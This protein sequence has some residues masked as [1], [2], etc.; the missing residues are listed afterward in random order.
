MTAEVREISK[1]YKDKTVLDKV[2]FEARS[3]ELVGIIGANGCG[4]STLLSVL[5]GVAERDGGDFLI[6]SVSLFSKGGARLRSTVGYVPQGEPLLEELSA[7]DNLRMWYS[8]KEIKSAAA[9]GGVLSMLGI[10]AFM[11]KR[12]SRMSG[13]MKRR[14]TIACAVAGDPKVL[15]L[16]EPTAS[17][18]A[19]CR[20]SI[21]AYFD[22]LKKRGCILI[23]ATH[24]IAEIGRCDR[25]YLLKDGT[26]APY[27][28]TPESLTELAEDL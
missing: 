13:G 26:A 18:D 19:E 5:A 2:S 14:L 10:D 28:R 6:D 15:L 24:S 20:S 11:N 12:V 25:V 17:L 8:E 4:K 23:A 22:S 21:Y 16:D 7:K 9:P 3:G 1:K 27:S